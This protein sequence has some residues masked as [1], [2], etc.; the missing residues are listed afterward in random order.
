MSSSQEPPV[1][2]PEPATETVEPPKRGRKRLSWGLAAFGLVALVAYPAWLLETLP[3]VAYL[4]RTNPEETALMRERGPERR[5]IWVPLDQI[6]ERL[7]QA[8][9]MGEDAGFYY[10]DGFDFHEMRKAFER[11]WKAGRTIRGASTLTQQLAKN[12]YLSTDRTYSRKLK[13][14]ILTRRIEKSVPKRRILEIYLNVIEWGDGVYGAEAA[15]RN[16]FGKSA[17]HLDAVEAAT[18]A[19]MIPNPRRLDPCERP[20]EV[21]TRRDRILG[22]MHVA[23]HLTDEELERARASEPRLR[24]CP[25]LPHAPDEPSEL[26]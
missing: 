10:H 4:A 24:G 3:D 5:Q 25:R 19:A 2:D 16:V 21:R 11:N 23:E 22:W 18:L 14:A 26:E 1:A 15:S 12:L 17:A 8:V 7:V 6:S 20:D 9:I 13:E